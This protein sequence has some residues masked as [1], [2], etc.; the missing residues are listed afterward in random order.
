MGDGQATLPD[1]MTTDGQKDFLT[2]HQGLGER[3]KAEQNQMAGPMLRKW[4][5][6]PKGVIIRH[7][8]H[9]IYTHT[10]CLPSTV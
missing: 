4:G 2:G 9:C 1:K 7:D 6:V 8:M 10:L 3:T 5:G